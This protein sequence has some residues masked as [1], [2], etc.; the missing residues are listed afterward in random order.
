MP[1][2]KP[3]YAELKAELRERIDALEEDLEAGREELEWMA[4]NGM[5]GEPAARHSFEAYGRTEELLER[6]RG[7][8]VE[9]VEAE[10][11]GEGAPV[12]DWW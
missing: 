12:P 9:L 7:D 4:R 8:L 11:R 5:Q 3:T 10:E 6:R 2:Y 1:T